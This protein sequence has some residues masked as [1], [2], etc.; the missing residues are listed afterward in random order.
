MAQISDN[1]YKMF[2]EQLAQ[3]FE[4]KVKGF[5]IPTSLLETP[6]GVRTVPLPSAE[7]VKEIDPSAIKDNELYFYTPSYKQ[8]VFH[9]LRHLRNCGSHKDYIT[10]RKKYGRWFYIFED[11]GEILGIPYV[12]LRGRVCC[13][14]WDSFIEGLYA[15]V[16]KEKRVPLKKSKKIV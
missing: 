12:S 3:R 16:L 7:C 14:V 2:S 10:K 15:Q 5:Y 4:R 13:D 8:G 1:E 6:Y 11:K 9:L